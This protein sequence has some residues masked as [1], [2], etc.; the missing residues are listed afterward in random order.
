[1]E[2]NKEIKDFVQEDFVQWL[3]T[4]CKYTPSIPVGILASMQPS[5]NGPDRD[6]SNCPLC[7]A[8]NTAVML[9]KELL[10]LEYYRAFML[11][12]FGKDATRYYRSIDISIV[13]VKT[14]AECL[15]VSNQAIYDMAHKFV[16]TSYNAAVANLAFNSKMQGMMLNDAFT[17]SS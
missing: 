5:K 13:N 1:M 15:K 17:F 3:K 16:K 11:V 14:H 8:F 7:S 6:Y 12:Y 10:G 4:R 9:Q 2:I